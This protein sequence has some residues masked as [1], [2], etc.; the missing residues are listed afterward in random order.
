MLKFSKMF[1]LNFQRLKSKIKLSHLRLRI[2]HL[3]LPDIQNKGPRTL[4]IVGGVVA[5]VIIAALGFVSSYTSQPGFC[6]KCHEMQPAYNAWKVSVH[7]DVGCADCHYQGF[8]GFFK[9][10]AALASDV[11]KHITK[12]YAVPINKSSSLSKEIHSDTCLTCHTPKRVVTPRRTLVMNHNIHIKKGINCTT[13]HNRVGHPTEKGYQTFISMEGCFR[14]HGLSKTAIAPGRCSACHPKSFGLI[15]VS[16]ALSHEAG[17]W[18]HGNHGKNAEKDI[19]PCRMCHQK[20]FCSGCHGVEV[21]H[22][23]K[24]IKKEHG[25]IGS[26]HPEICQKCHQQQDFCNACHHKAYNY[27]GP[28][29][30][31]VPTHRFAVAKVGPASCFNCHSPTFCAYCHVRGEEPPRTSKPTQE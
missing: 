30:G 4:L 9:Q 2:P 28:P 19:T 27:N 17:T 25:G 6:A 8:F 22:S 20:T 26:K 14:C 1:S 21:P 11:F 29:G 12:S 23:E 15:P 16:G 24:F 13:C 5:L 10:K 31:W 7:A 3:R 18:L